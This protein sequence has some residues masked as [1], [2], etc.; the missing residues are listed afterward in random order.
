TTS[1]SGERP[2]SWSK[3]AS[4]SASPSSKAWR[5]SPPCNAATSRAAS[6]CSPT[7]T[8]GC[9]SRPTPRPGTRT[10]S[11]GWTR[12]SSLEG[13]AGPSPREHAAEL[14]QRL[15]QRLFLADDL[16]E[17]PTSHAVFDP[18]AE[19]PGVAFDEGGDGFGDD[20]ERPGRDRPRASR[21]STT[22]STDPARAARAV[23]WVSAG[24]VRR[25]GVG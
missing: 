13:G 4:T 9:S 17:R 25:A 24:A 8:T 20:D 7:R 11:A 6:S 22:T 3:E 12:T 19:I 2:C 5:A 10:C 1:T 21:R 15:G 16:L 18:A 23:W 14:Q